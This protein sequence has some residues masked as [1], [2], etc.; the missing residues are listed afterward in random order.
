MDSRQAILCIWFFHFDEH[1]SLY[2]NK[3]KKKKKKRL[4]FE[5]DMNVAFRFAKIPIPFDQ[6]FFVSASRLTMGIV[7]TS[8][9]VPGHVLAVPRRLSA[10]M[11]ELSVDEVADLFHSAQCIGEAISKHW[12]A[13]SLTFTVQD[14]VD[15]GQTVPHV[16]VHILPRRK[17]DFGDNDEIYVAIDDS[18]K[19]LT[20]ASHADAKPRTRRSDDVM[21]QEA[22]Q[23]RALMNQ[24]DIES[25]LDDIAQFDQ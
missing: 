19:R 10:R 17:G 24:H 22:L 14:G 21:R 20:N 3:M 1:T 6:C 13:T 18:E 5:R 12:S 11:S 7:N 16:H 15:A 4:D 9:V 2:Y 23:L 8:P 25:L